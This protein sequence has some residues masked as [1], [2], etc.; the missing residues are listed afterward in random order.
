MILNK[1]IRRLIASLLLIYTLTGFYGCSFQDQNDTS[2]TSNSE[3]T[4][5]QS[6]GY[7]LRSDP[8]E[9]GWE[10]KNVLPSHIREQLIAEFEARDS[11][12]PPIREI[13]L[14]D[15]TGE[16][17]YY[18]YFEE[19]IQTAEEYVAANERALYQKKQKPI[20]DYIKE[21]FE[22]GFMAENRAPH[23]EIIVYDQ[24]GVPIYSRYY[25][26][27]IDT[28]EEYAAAVDEAW[29]HAEE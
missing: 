1:Q 5:T 11:E 12:R 10:S 26:D 22:A 9:S 14:Y 25:E 3:I 8:V 29:Q 21:A 28:L 6:D 20:P 27:G 18:E 19:G 24:N 17:E 16:I 4:A 23:S 15:H 2:A 13:V 7:L